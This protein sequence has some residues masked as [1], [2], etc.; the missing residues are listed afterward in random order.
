MRGLN[1]AGRRDLVLLIALVL[2]VLMVHHQVSIAPASW[3]PG[4]IGVAAVPG[5]INALLG[6]LVVVLFARFLL[7]GARGHYSDPGE[8][9]ELDHAPG[10]VLRW[11]GAALLLFLFIAGLGVERIPFEVLGLLYLAFTILVIRGCSWRNLWSAL[12]V[13]LAV[14]IAVSL[15]FSRLFGVVLP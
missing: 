14:V 10:A 9:S 2:V 6:A 7:S 5:L 15:V 1:P 4:D 3:F 12:A 13:S 11:F 8:E